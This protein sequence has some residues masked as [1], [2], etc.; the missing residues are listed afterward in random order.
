MHVSHTPCRSCLPLLALALLSP[1]LLDAC[2]TSNAGYHPGEDAADLAGPV[3]RSDGRTGDGPM[4]K[5]DAQ[6]TSD[7]G[8]GEDVKP[9]P[10]LEP[11]PDLKPWPPE[12][13]LNG[14]DDNGNNLVDCEDPQCQPGYVCLAPPPTGWLGVGWVDAQTALPCP[15]PFQP[16]VSLFDIG[17]LSAPP[18]SCACGCG[19]VQEAGCVVDLACN[20][21]PM[22]GLSSAS[23][24]LGAGCTQVKVPAGGQWNSCVAS[25]PQ[26]VNGWCSPV[27]SGAAP[28][29]SW[30]PST[31]GC[32]AASGGKCADPGKLCVAKLVGAKGPCIARPGDQ[33]C[34]PPPSPYSVKTLYYNGNVTDTRGC[35]ALG[36]TCGQGTGA[37]CGCTGALCL[38]GIHGSNSCMSGFLATVPLNGTC[39]QVNDPNSN[40]G[41]WGVLR[42]G[43][44]LTNAGSCPVSGL[45]TPTGSVSPTGPITVCCTP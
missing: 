42:V 8:P 23:V 33:S 44:G 17:N 9:W 45:G 35:S 10:D 12:N 29:Y 6:P 15:A 18:A 40:D 5:V 2:T 19:A 31:R 26:G 20:P 16:A 34:P 21:G 13:C 37:T 22:C 32:V 36:C 7:K 4:V 28:P 25:A 41:I 43:V 24:A 38:L 1:L 14:V 11:W 27:A 30:L 39:A 3:V